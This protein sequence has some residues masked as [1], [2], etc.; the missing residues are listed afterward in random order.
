M[1]AQQIFL[2]TEFV[3]SIVQKRIVFVIFKHQHSI[4][5]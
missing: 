4:N 5:D 2:H 1:I 3:I